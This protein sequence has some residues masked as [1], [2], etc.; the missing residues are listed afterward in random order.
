MP[1]DSITAKDRTIRPPHIDADGVDLST[2]VP[3]RASDDY[4]VLAAWY[5]GFAFCEMYRKVVLAQCREIVRAK[6]VAKEV[7]I[8][9]ARIDDLARTH[10]IY[11][12]YLATHLE[13]RELWER[14]FLANGGM[15]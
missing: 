2:T 7:R 6:F 4:P 12:T 8:S 3:E 11:M 10:P 5:S 13:G 9:E 1:A 15:R 14:A